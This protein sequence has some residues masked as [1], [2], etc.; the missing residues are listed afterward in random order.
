[1]SDEQ[2][3]AGR[4]VAAGVDGRQGC[5]QGPLPVWWDVG[6][7]LEEKEGMCIKTD[8]RD[9]CKQIVWLRTGLTNSDFSGVFEEIFRT[10]NFLATLKKIERR[11]SFFE[12]K[13]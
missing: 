4:E 5:S 12:K 13:E 8:E 2:P 7:L 10:H 1:L 11:D 3:P 9:D 6:A